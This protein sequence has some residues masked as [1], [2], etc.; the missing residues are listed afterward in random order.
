MRKCSE[1]PVEEKWLRFY[2]RS[3]KQPPATVIYNSREGIVHSR[4]GIIC[5]F[6]YALSARIARVFASPCLA[7][8]STPFARRSSLAESTESTPVRFLIGANSFLRSTS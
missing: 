2:D 5:L 1:F 7:Y 8:S 6:V 3:K 4:R